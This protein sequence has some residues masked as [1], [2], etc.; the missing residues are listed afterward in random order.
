VRVQAHVRFGYPYASG[1][2]LH[3]V[4]GWTRNQRKYNGGNSRG[5]S[6]PL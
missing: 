5:Q 3:Q 1:V 2:R 6:G 4:S